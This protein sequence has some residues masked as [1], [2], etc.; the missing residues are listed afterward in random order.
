MIRN[1]LIALHNQIHNN[2]PNY[3]GALHSK[4]CNFRYDSSAESISEIY[5]TMSIFGEKS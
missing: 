5:G 1:K 2:S 3:V 4:A